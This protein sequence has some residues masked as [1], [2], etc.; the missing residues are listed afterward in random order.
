[1]ART[2]L[3]GANSI[4]NI[5]NTAAKSGTTNNNKDAWTIGYNTDIVV[6]AWAGNNDASPMNG[7]SGLIVTPIWHDIITEAINEG[8]KGEPFAKPEADYAD[9]KPILKGVWRTGGPSSIHSIL[10]WVDRNNPTGPIPNNPENDSQ[11]INWEYAVQKFVNSG[12]YLGYSNFGS[13]SGEG[14]DLDTDPRVNLDFQVIG[15]KESY[16]ISDTVVASIASSSTIKNVAIFIDSNLA[17]SSSDTGIVSFT[18][19]ENLLGQG[20]SH[21]IRVLVTSEEGQVGETSQTFSTPSTTNNTPDNDPPSDTGS[22]ILQP[23]EE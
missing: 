9:L 12:E 18:L 20:N 17:A 5:P 16:Q 4:V 19:E 21:V 10:T 23:I 8:Y 14:F 11:F 15:L 1:M 3:W 6:G 22:G 7:L 2:P 13:Y